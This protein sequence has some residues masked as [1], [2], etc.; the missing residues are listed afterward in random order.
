M[1]SK[2]F[3]FV[4]V[5]DTS[6]VASVQIAKFLSERLDI[7]ICWDESINDEALD[8][9]VIVNGA[10]AFSGSM[11]LEALG[12]AI[13]SATR[14]VWIQNDYTIIPPKDESGAE[15]P[16]RKAFRTRHALSRAPVDYWTTV[17]AMSR[18]GRSR[19]GHICGPSSRHVNWN[20]LTM[21]TDHVAKMFGN[22]VLGG[23]MVYYGSFRKDRIVAFDKFFSKPFVRTVIS[24]PSRKFAERYIHP[25]VIHDG[26]QEDIVSYVGEFGLGLYLED[27]KSSSEFHSPGNRF[28]EMLSAGLPIVFQPEAMRM[29]E[30]A[31]YEIADWTIWDPEEAPE[32]M[33]RQ[34]QIF[35]DQREAW[36]DNAITERVNLIET[37]KSAWSSLT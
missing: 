37:L 1:N 18:P 24:S 3:S 34:L 28:Y 17:E 30:R 20:C 11:L 31:G 32:F 19:S 6:M 21:E 13:E 14:V 35:Q 15:S 7:P 12:S 10:F 16:F 23:S 27:K 5:S 9:L 4:K 26:K 29:M 2:I 25:L 36:R 8:I 33:E 22:R